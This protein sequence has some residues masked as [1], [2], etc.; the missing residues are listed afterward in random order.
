MSQVK[1]KGQFIKG[2]R[3]EAEVQSWCYGLGGPL[4]ILSMGFM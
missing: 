1:G 3:C 2:T 4:T